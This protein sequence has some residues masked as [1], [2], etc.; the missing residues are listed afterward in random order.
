TIEANFI[1]IMN[2]L[3]EWSGQLIFLGSTNITPLLK[4]I[5]S[6]IP[7]QSIQWRVTVCNTMH[8]I[9]LKG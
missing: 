5:Q 9:R 7:P 8:Q 6:P 3:L 1:K 2:M 4:H